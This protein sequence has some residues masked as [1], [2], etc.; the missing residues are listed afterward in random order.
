[1]KNLLVLLLLSLL[2]PSCKTNLDGLFPPPPPV[3]LPLETQNGANTFGCILNGQTWEAS[4]HGSIRPFVYPSPD[5]HYSRG[6]LW[7]SAGR[8]TE[9]QSPFLGFTIYVSR[10]NRLGMYVLSRRPDRTTSTYAYAEV[11]TDNAYAPY[12]TDSVRV[13]SITIVQLDTVSARKFVSGRFEL[14]ARPQ[15]GAAP[16]NGFPAE[17]TVTHGRFDVA[18]NRP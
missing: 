12:S 14:V 10:L 6:T 9:V 8:R 18:L 4:S 13:G 1:M 16:P 3:Q 17:A 11:S 15:K 7:L 2:L 5:A